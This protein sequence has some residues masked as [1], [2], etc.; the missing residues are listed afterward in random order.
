MH[1]NKEE[2][3]E[4]RKWR[5]SI[6]YKTP[7]WHVD[8]LL[9][10][11]LLASCTNYIA[12]KNRQR[13]SKGLNMMKCKKLLTAVEYTAGTNKHTCYFRARPSIVPVSP[14]LL[15]CQQTAC[16][17]LSCRDPWMPSRQVPEDVLLCPSC[18]S[19]KLNALEILHLPC[20]QQPHMASQLKIRKYA[21]ISI[22]N[23]Q[24]SPFNMQMCWNIT[25][26]RLL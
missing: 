13:S 15:S 3:V 20:T 25:E 12:E 7:K 2:Q 4:R 16:G 23:G 17:R 24:L 22:P 8:A 26:H 21:Y 18:L 10:N 11:G 19:N 6:K 9:W 14:V 1:L 5:S